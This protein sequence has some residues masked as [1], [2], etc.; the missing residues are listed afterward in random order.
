MYGCCEQ[1]IKINSNQL[2]DGEQGPPA[3][4]SKGLFY[5]GLVTT[6]SVNV[7]DSS[8]QS[9][10]HLF[11]NP[12]GYMCQV[13]RETPPPRGEGGHYL[14]FS[15]PNRNQSLALPGQRAT[16]GEQSPHEHKHTHKFKHSGSTYSNFPEMYIFSKHTCVCVVKL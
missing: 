11:R 4:T 8:T 7:V 2:L 3:A 5:F 9:H 13:Q 10:K 15:V 12:L 6:L 14:H 16:T 1:M